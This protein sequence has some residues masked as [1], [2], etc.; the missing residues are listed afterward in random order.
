GIKSVKV[1]KK[2]VVIILQNIGGMP[3]PFDVIVNTKSGAEKIYH[4]TS[5]VW[6]NNNNE[7]TI[8]IE[9]LQELISVK[10]DGGI[11]MDANTADNTWQLN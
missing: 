5:Q 7:T 8:I 6:Q 9:G 3:A 11:F 2:K 1:D 10:I 4:K